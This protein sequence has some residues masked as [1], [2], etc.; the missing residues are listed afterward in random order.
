MRS[1]EAAPSEGERLAMEL[2]QVSGFWSLSV[3]D[4]RRKDV[5]GFATL[6]SP[7]QLVCDPKVSGETGKVLL[8]QFCTW[9]I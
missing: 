5:S 7:P 3:S 6:P 2:R 9:G 4:S 1:G 8:S